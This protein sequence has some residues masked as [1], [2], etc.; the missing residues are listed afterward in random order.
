MIILKIMMLSL[1]PTFVINANQTHNNA[2]IFIN[3]GQSNATGNISIMIQE[4]IIE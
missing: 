3:I 4:H 1:M 2:Y